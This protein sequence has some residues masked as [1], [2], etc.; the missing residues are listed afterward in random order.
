MQKVFVQKRNP[1]QDWNERWG[2]IR[3]NNDQ[4]TERLR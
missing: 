4:T 2:L 1:D 3:F